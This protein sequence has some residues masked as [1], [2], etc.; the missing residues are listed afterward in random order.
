M[1][2]K[3]GTEVEVELNPQHNT[4]RWNYATKRIVG[5][6]LGVQ[7]FGASGR[8]V[9]GVVL[10]VK[11]RS[12]APDELKATIHLS[13]IGNR[14]YQ[15]PTWVFNDQLNYPGGPRFL[16]KGCECGAD[17]V[18]GSTNMTHSHWCPKHI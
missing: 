4:P 3:I 12:S 14:L 2:I 7:D 1:Q 15:T 5:A 8:W 10:D 13:E 17:T 6:P 9:K 18:Y 16:E 11:P